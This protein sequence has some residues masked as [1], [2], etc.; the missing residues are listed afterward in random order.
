MVFWI[1][2]FMSNSVQFQ[3]KSQKRFFCMFNSAQAQPSIIN[4]YY[5]ILIWQ[6]AVSINNNV[7]IQIYKCTI[8]NVLLVKYFTCLIDSKHE[9]FYM[10]NISCFRKLNN[11]TN[12]SVWRVPA[13]NILQYSAWEPVNSR[14]GNLHYT[15]ITSKTVE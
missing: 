7:L 8:K 14:I 10:F 1:S 11:A 3:S 5:F 13:F 15:V 2:S 12:R 4:Q 9:L 6:T